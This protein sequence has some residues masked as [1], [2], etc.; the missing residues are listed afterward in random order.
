ME[1]L[2]EAGADIVGI[3][4]NNL[5]ETEKG[6]QDAGRK[7][8]GIEADLS[9]IGVI[10]DIIDRAMKE[11]GRIDP[12]RPA[13]LVFGTPLR[14]RGRGGEEHEEIVRFITSNLKKWGG[15]VKEPG[16]TI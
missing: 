5:G 7:F 16:A 1:A 9:K 11:F 8:L 14:I 10:A 4:L 13:H 15:S 12:S 6:V 2:A 3:D